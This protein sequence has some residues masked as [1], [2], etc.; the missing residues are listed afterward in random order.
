MLLLA[1]NHMSL[2]I[3][4][5]ERSEADQLENPLVFGQAYFQRRYD[6]LTSCYPG[7]IKGAESRP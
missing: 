7:I 5:C 4:W 1:S 3:G 2:E 6:P